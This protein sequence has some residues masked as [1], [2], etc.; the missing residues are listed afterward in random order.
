MGQMTV[1]TRVIGNISTPV[2]VSLSEALVRS[3]MI[4]R[5]AMTKSKVLGI[6][7]ILSAL[8]ATPVLAAGFEHATRPWPAPV[9]HRQPRAADIPTSAV[10]RQSPDQEDENVDRKIRNICRGC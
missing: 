7:A 10:S 1:S 9:G 5:H 2:R 6:T 8:I 3:E 4:W